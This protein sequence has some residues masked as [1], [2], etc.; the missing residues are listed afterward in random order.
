MT[1]VSTAGMA[2]RLRSGGGEAPG[3][4]GLVAGRSA[5]GASRPSGSSGS[6]ATPGGAA[7]AS[8]GR[9]ERSGLL[10]C[11]AASTG[12][13]GE[14]AAGRGIR[15]LY[16][17]PAGSSSVAVLLAVPFAVELVLESAARAAAAI[18]AA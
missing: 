9:R 4:D 2:L 10:T 1:G 15:A 6:A 11:S 18:L 17:S 7:A 14:W 5:S 8:A 12:D 16:Q 3:D 13:A